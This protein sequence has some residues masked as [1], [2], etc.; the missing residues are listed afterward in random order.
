MILVTHNREFAAELTDDA[1]FFEDGRITARG[2]LSAI[3][4]RFNW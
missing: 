1:A 3:A 2:R 4:E